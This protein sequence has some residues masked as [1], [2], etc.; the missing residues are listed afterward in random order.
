MGEADLARARAL[1]ISSGGVGAL[2]PPSPM[3]TGGA[4]MKATLNPR[5]RP[6]RFDDNELA[7]WLRFWYAGIR[8][9]AA[10]CTGGGCCCPSVTGLASGHRWEF[11]TSIR[12]TAILRGECLCRRP[13]WC[14]SD[15]EGLDEDLDEG[16]WWCWFWSCFSR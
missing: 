13:V 3:M 5:A 4:S 2:S 1:E 6:F 7:D 12:G 8:K 10:G 15:V 9:S 11:E 16:C 14:E